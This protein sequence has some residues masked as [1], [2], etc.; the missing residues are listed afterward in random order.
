MSQPGINEMI[1][2]CREEERLRKATEELLRLALN[3][4]VHLRAQVQELQE[5]NNEYMERARKA[6]GLRVNPDSY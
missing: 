5:S 3:E 6:E 4:N 1:T 2:R